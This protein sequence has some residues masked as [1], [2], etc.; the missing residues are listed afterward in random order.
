MRS[1]RC[2]LTAV[3][4]QSQTMYKSYSEL[5]AIPNFVDRFEYLKLDGYVGSETFGFDRYIN[6]VLYNSS[7]W[8]NF[9]RDI[10]IR[11]NSCDLAHPDYQL[12]GFILIHHLNPLTIKMIQN[13]SSEVFDPENVVCVSHRT[14]NAIHYGN[15]DQ[16]MKDFVGRSANDTCPW[17]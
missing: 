1:K 3:C 17:K 2:G 13:R 11:D 4:K 15:K 16:L 8:R 5:V 12:N 10:I 6:Q 7:E 9:R 14:H